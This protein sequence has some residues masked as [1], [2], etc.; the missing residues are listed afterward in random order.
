MPVAEPML[1]RSKSSVVTAAY[2]PRFSSPITLSFGMRTLSKKTS[3]NSWLLPRL[4][5]GRTS[6]PGAFMSRMK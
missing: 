2:Q 3:L 5:S 1:E 6:T 4:Y